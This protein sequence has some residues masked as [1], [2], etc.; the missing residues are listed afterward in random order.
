MFVKKQTA[1]TITS[2]LESLLVSLW[3][4]YLYGQVSEPFPVLVLKALTKKKLGMKMHE[5]RVLA[6]IEYL[7][8]PLQEIERSYEFP[9]S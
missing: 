2:L 8:K 7:G 3:R 1:S 6:V 5:K 9:M 4:E